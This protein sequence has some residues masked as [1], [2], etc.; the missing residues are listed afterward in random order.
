MIKKGKTGMSGSEMVKY[1]EIHHREHRVHREK[2]HRS[3]LSVY[4]VV[5]KLYSNSLFQ[6]KLKRL[7]IEWREGL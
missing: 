4:Y 3:V 1:E 2:L 7:R 5:E 6:G